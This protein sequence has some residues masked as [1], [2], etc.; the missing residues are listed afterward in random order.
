MEEG[1]RRAAPRHAEEGQQRAA[2]QLAEEGR[3]R[4]APEIEE[5][6]GEWGG[7]ERSISESVEEVRMGKELS[8]PLV[9]APSK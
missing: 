3:Q 2:P 7:G 9:G 6:A 1:R 8:G 4:A 5:E